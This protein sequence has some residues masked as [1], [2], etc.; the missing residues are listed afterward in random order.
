LTPRIGL[1]ERQLVAELNLK[2]RL[3]MADRHEGARGVHSANV[4]SILSPGGE[5][6]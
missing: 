4:T 2:E 3:A 5:P 6:G 1:K